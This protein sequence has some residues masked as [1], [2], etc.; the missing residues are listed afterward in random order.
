MKTLKLIFTVFLFVLLAAGNIFAQTS[1]RNGTAT[2]TQLLVPVGARGISMAGATITNSVGIEALYWNPANVARSQYG[3]DVMASH[4]SYIAD[5]G[6][7]YAAVA[8]HLGDLGVLSLS[9]KNFD[10][11]SIERTTIDNPDGTGQTYEPQFLTLGFSYSK[12]LSDRVSVGLTMN[13]ITERLEF[14]EQSGVAF[15]IGVTYTDLASIN[16]LSMAVVLKNLGPQMQYTGSAFYTEAE[17][18]GSSR[19]AQYYR[20]ETAQFELPSVFELGFGYAYDLNEQNALDFS[21]T[22]RNN[23][24]FEDEYNFGL[25]YGY[26]NLFFVRGGYNYVPELDSEYHIY[27][28]SL[29]AGLNYNLGDM[30]LKFDYAYQETQYFEDN[31]VFAVTLGL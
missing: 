24:F 9:I 29:G 14:A 2:A 16:G 22:F 6:V 13:L 5:I 19:G 4:M 11:E 26:D 21:G 10:I 12:M 3:V 7:Q 30:N 18:E 20:L 28:L 23:N 1:N 17:E 27:G 31:H 15:D 25:E 8:A